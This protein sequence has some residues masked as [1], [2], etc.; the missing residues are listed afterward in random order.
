MRT[1]IR[2]SEKSPNEWP[3]PKLKHLRKITHCLKLRHSMK[4]REQSR[5]TLLI[6]LS[7]ICSAYFLN[8]C[9][10][11]VQ[12]TQCKSEVPQR[13]SNKEICD[14]FAKKWDVHQRVQ[15]N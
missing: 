7:L 9:Q 2:S 5:H 13:G 15:R 10:I 3:A 4:L 12:Q 1:R 14:L 11:Q 8:G 6:V